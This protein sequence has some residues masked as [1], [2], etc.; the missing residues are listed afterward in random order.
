MLID[1]F[2]GWSNSF[3][4]LITLLSGKVLYFKILILRSMTESIIQPEPFPKYFCM[5]YI[6]VV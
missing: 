3:G 4:N 6:I 5:F 1:V 2:L